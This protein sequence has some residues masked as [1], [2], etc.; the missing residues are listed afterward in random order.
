MAERQKEQLTGIHKVLT[1][2]ATVTKDT[3]AE[4]HNQQ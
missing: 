1:E 4:L 3:V 2:A